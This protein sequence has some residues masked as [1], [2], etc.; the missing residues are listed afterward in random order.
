MIIFMSEILVFTNRKLC[1]EDLKKR[2]E[3]IAAAQPKAIVLREKDLEPTE[4][5]SL[6]RT[7]ADICKKH[8]VTCILHNFVSSAAELKHD[9]IHLPMHILSRLTDDDKK[10]FKILGASCHS[11]E[12]AITAQRLGCTY[13]TVGHIFDTDCK[14]GLPGRGTGF[15]KEVCKSVVIPVYAI[16]GISPDNIAQVSDT[17]ADGACIMS[18]A[19][20]CENPKELLNNFEVTK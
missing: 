19:M 3:K 2:L 16:G 12:D 13:I 4:Y 9:A 5:T 8:S 6:A 20:Q 14:K 15:L 1:R 7:A 11:I 18:S 17:G 10:N